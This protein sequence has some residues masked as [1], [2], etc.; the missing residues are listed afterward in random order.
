MF[1]TFA[2][3]IITKPKFL[4]NIL[5][6]DQTKWEIRIEQKK[7]ENQR[8]KTRNGREKQAQTNL[9][10]HS[11]LICNGKKLALNKNKTT[12]GAFVCA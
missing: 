2:L 3:S 6:K 5:N 11:C 10:V 7:Q 1:Y 12:L 4:P 9:L 8:K